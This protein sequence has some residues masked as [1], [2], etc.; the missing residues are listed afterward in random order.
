MERHTRTYTVDM[1][2][3]VCVYVRVCVPRPCALHAHMFVRVCRHH[4]GPD[5]R[6]KDLSDVLLAQFDKLLQ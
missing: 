6:L 3:H 2:A 1:C 5:V 4:S